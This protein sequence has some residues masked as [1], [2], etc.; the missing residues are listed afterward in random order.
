MTSF[1]EVI[2]VD[3]REMDLYLA[4][5]EDPGPFPAI[6]VIQHAGGVDTFTRSMTDRL[7]S[8]GYAAAAPDLYHRLGDSSLDNMAKL[9]QLKD[10]EMIA[11]VDATVKFL[12]EHDAVD[13]SALGI[14]G[15]CMGGRVVYLMAAALSAFRA[16][17]A[18]YGGNIK[19]PWGEGVEAP[20][21][22]TLQIS[23]P[24]LFHFGEDDTNPSPD[25]MHELDTELARCGKEHEFYS[26]PHA[27]HGFMDFTRTDRHR[28]EADEMAWT[29]TLKF[30]GRY[31][32][33]G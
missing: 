30:F 6:V 8:A 17:V 27:G 10:D 21:S 15:F 9:K 19:V 7:A 18:F 2:A 31:L 4:L 3:K 25:D 1:A 24:V 20:F 22:Q 32:R 16:A 12:K 13:D 26:Y 5:P 23:C 14:T 11:D 29:R 28:P 33:D